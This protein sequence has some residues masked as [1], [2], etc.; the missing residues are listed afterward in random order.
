MDSIQMLTQ[1]WIYI[2]YT[3]VLPN[4]DSKQAAIQ[5]NYRN[6]HIPAHFRVS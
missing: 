4:A 2:S 5:Y 6:G 3:S 1:F